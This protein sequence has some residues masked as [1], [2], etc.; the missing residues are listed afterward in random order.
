M[1][2]RGAKVKDITA[3]FDVQIKFPERDTESC[4]IPLTNGEESSQPNVNDIIRIT[5]RPENCERAKK[6]LL[7][8]V[9]ID[10]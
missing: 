5:G 8:Q 2:A 7:E 4:E 9:Y 3:E 10:I 1:G 6:A